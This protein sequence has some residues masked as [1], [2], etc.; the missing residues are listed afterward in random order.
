MDIPVSEYGDVN[1]LLGEVV[2]GIRGVL[3]EKV[4]GIY[5]YG[6]LVMGDFDLDISDLDLLAAL[7]SGLDEGELAGLERMHSELVG[8]WKEWDDRIEVQY[9]PLEGLATF[10]EKATKM[11]NISP[12]EPL[13]FVEAGIDWLMNWYMIR[14]KGIVLYGPPAKEIIG[15][16]SKEEFVEAAVE[17]IKG[18]S[19]WIE[20]TRMWRSYQSYVILTACRSLYLWRNGEQVS[21]RRA[22]EWAAKE[23]PEWAGLIRDAWRWRAEARSEKDVDPEVTY[24]LAVEFVGYVGELLEAK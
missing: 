3:G 15:P 18:A 14:E 5:L 22:M 11:G 13:H 9:M 19:E 8:K 24:P 17:H 12:G 20:A 23:L 21:K 2:E 4:A 7:R 6:S 1:G 16:I 10:R